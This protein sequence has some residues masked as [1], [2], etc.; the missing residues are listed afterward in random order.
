MIDFLEMQGPF[1]ITFSGEGAYP[2]YVR[3]T[4]TDVLKLLRSDEAF[5]EELFTEQELIA[6]FRDPDNWNMSEDGQTPLCWRLPIGEI[7]QVHVD[8]LDANDFAK[9]YST[10]GNGQWD[11]TRATQNGRPAPTCRRCGWAVN[12]D[13]MD[14]HVCEGESS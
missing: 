8:C 4:A 14:E 5:G 11:W 6:E 13:S 1:A 9:R 12:A 10:N 2:G 3:S 7:S